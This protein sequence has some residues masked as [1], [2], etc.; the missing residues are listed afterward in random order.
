MGGRGE[1]AEKEKG[2][3]STKLEADEEEE[4]EEDEA[5]TYPNGPPLTKSPLLTDATTSYGSKAQ[6][7]A[8]QTATRR[9]KDE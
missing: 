5:I 7:R 3:T 2:S 4:E 8:V 6:T 9:W 1:E